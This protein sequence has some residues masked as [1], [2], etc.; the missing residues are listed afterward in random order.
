MDVQAE[1]FLNEA[2]T[3]FM[4]PLAAFGEPDIVQLRREVEPVPPDVVEPVELGEILKQ[5]RRDGGVRPCAF[6]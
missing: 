3:D 1:I 4:M 5:G 6:L 2:H